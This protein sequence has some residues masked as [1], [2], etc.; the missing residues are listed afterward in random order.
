[1][2]GGA[3]AYGGKALGNEIY[4]NNAKKAADFIISN[5]IDKEGNLLA[6]Y[7]AE[8]AYNYGFLEDYAFF[9]FGL[10]KLYEATEDQVY[11]AIAKK[12]K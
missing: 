5:C 11:L 8:K 1:M 10:L 3:L 4:I 9:I 7:I 6:V 12:I 2:I